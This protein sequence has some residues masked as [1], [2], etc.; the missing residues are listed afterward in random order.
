MFAYLKLKNM[1]DKKMF[2]DKWRDLKNM[3]DKGMISINIMR[4]PTSL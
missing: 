4:V 2:V 3:K 1:S